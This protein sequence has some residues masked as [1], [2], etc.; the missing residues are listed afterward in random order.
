MN[1]CIYIFLMTQMKKNKKLAYAYFPGSLV[2][3]CH[4]KA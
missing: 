4:G 2:N 3:I 1:K